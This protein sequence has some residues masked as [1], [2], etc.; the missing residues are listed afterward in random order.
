MT[1]RNADVFSVQGYDTGT[2]L[3]DAMASVEGDV[4]AKKELI[5]SMEKVE[6]ASPR[7]KFTFSK[8]HTAEKTVNDP[9]TG[10]KMV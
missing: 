2:L 1:G 3:V 6:I 5:V 8:A 4:G 9:A 7:G 10:C